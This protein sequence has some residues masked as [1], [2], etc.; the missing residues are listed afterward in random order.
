[1][2][3]WVSTS[4]KQVVGYLSVEDFCAMTSYEFPDNPRLIR[5]G[6]ELYRNERY[7]FGALRAS[8]YA[9]T[10]RWSKER[11]TLEHIEGNGR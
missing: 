6:V 9:P 1:M 8:N 11:Q 4:D 7:I 3:I 10:L 2:V 5:N